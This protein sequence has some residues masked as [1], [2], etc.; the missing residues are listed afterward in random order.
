MPDPEPPL[1]WALVG[2]GQIGARHAPQMVRSGV[3]TAIA[4][5]DLEKAVRLADASHA[6]AVRLADTRRPNAYPSLEA[7]LAAESPDLV[8]ICTPNWLHASQSILAL[9]SGCHVLCEKPMCL[10]TKEANEML[11]AARRANRQLFV[12]KQN[13]FN[14][15]VQLLYRLLQEQRLGRVL[16][17]QV[18]AFWHRPAAYYQD[19][20]GKKDLDGGILFTQFSHFIDLLCWLLGELQV[21]CTLQDNFLMRDHIE[22]EDTGIVVLKTPDGAIGTMHYTVAAWSKNMEGSITVLGEKGTVKIG[23]EYLNELDYFRVEGMETP[24]LASSRPANEYGA[25]KGSM[26]NHDKVYDELV[27]ALRDRAHALASAEQA[28]ETVALIEKIK[29]AAK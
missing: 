7:L 5:I 20:H 28:A 4:D 14:P 21:T 17:F 25:Y 8:A 2:A 15:P 27:N 9:R 22:G 3:L 16:S 11:D 19:W 23:G 26:S 13:R 12:V 6:N 18:N 24:V 29:S 10:T 1:R